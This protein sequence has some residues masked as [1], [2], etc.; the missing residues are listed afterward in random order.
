MVPSRLSII[1]GEVSAASAENLRAYFNQLAAG[2]EADQAFLIQG[3]MGVGVAKVE[4]VG[5]DAVAKNLTELTQDA[6]VN[7]L[8]SSDPKEKMRAMQLAFHFYKGERSAKMAAA[9]SSK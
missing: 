7:M 1:E 5:E 9:E 8:N 4:G 6:L 2:D 3:M